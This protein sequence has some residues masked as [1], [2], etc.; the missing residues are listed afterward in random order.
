MEGTRT[1]GTD[2]RNEKP[3][4]PGNS[5]PSENIARATTCEQCDQLQEHIAMLENVIDGLQHSENELIEDR[6]LADRECRRLR[7]EAAA[8]RREL[9]QLREEDPKSK[10]IKA[11]LEYWQERTNHTRSMIPI[12]GDRAAAVR[13][14]LRWKVPVGKLRTAIDMAAEYPYLVYGQPAKQ[15]KDP[16][17]KRRNDITDI[18]KN[19]QRIEAY[20]ALAT[21]P[22]STPPAIKP[23]IRVS[24]LK[25]GEKPI[26]AFLDRLEDA[27]PSG[28]N[29]WEARCPAH[30]D[31]HAS[32]SV[33][34]GRQGVVAHCHAG[35]AIENI[36]RA[37]GLDVAD[38]FDRDPEPAAPAPKQEAKPLQMEQQV[39]QWRE[40]LQAHTGL[41]ARLQEL[42]G[43]TPQTLDTLHVGF[44][45]QRLTLPVRDRDGQ[46][47]N[48]LRYLP[49]RKD[50]E[51]K[52]LAMKGRPR[53][54]FPSPETLA[55]D[56]VWLFEGEPDA[57]TGLELGLKAAALP[58]VNGWRVEW[59]RRFTDRRVIV[60]LD[61]DEQGRKAAQ[62]VIPS[63]MDHAMEVR[64][65]DLDPGRDDGFDVSDFVKGGGTAGELL[66]LA[67][68]AG[69]V[70][71]L[72]E[73][74]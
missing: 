55:G 70:V 7:K 8:L 50:G 74:A 45:G 46:L 25:P 52:L 62:R 6:D 26:D 14:A 24:N 10:Q 44:D 5:I 40:R 30:D 71:R 54:L 11:I 16:S 69:A 27:K 34:Q 56:E 1:S 65:V 67:L 9:Q 63:L 29:K 38:L 43:W 48:I 51:R 3:R 18:L 64:V 28:L 68:R 35:C 19:E 49:V 66:K 15:P 17:E 41:L 42:R 72:G 60:C 22:A 13:R 4:A 37:I 31:R 33:A 58:G 36:A 39:G 59:A 23:A 73:A 2:L 20:A 12:D 53:D 32:L 61:C 57:I 21:Q 47:Q